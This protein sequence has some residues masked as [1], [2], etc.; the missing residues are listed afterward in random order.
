MAVGAITIVENPAT[1][2][3]DSTGATITKSTDLPRMEG[4]LHNHGPEDVWLSVSVSSSAPD[5]VVTTGAQAQLQVPLPAGGELP[6]LWHYTKITH[7]TAGGTS[8]LSWKPS[9]ARK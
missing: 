7:K 9:H 3:T 8:T 1:I 4:V 5:A 2:E 6:W